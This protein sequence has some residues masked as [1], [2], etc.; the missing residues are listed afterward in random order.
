MNKN[1]SGGFVFVLIE[2]SD[3]GGTSVLIIRV[4]HNRIDN[5]FVCNVESLLNRSL[6]FLAHDLEDRLHGGLAFLHFN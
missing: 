1:F 3:R 4:S 6:D 2:K 5:D